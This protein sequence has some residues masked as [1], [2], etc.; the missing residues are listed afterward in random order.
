VRCCGDRPLACTYAISV[1]IIWATL[2]RIGRELAEP[3]AL[4]RERPDIGWAR[5]S[6]RLKVRRDKIAASRRGRATL[7]SIAY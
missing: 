2:A 3:S 5:D 7:S 6:R 1:A 4:R